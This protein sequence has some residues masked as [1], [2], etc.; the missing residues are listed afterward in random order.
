MNS[1]SITVD[2]P[3]KLAISRRPYL[4]PRVPQVGKRIPGYSSLPADTK[5][6]HDDQGYPRDE[7]VEEFVI[8]TRSGP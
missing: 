6:M 1:W 2:P 7:I 4:R 8:K 5:R 3:R